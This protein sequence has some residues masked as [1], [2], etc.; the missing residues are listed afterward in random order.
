MTAPPSLEASVV[1][2]VKDDPRIFRLLTSLACQSVSTDRFEVLVVENGSR[3][4]GERVSA[5]GGHVRYLH[6]PSSNPAAARGVGLQAARGRFLLLT[7]ADCVVAEDWIECLTQRLARGDLAAVGGVIEKYSPQS[8]T[9]RHGI[10]VVDGQHSLNYLPALDLPYVV[11]ANAGYVA[12][13]VREV[14]GF[15]E[16]LPSGSDVDICYR[17]GLAGYA[18]GLAPNA[19]VRHED[20]RTIAAHFDRFRYYAEYQVLLF[21]KYRSHSG[22]RFVLNPYPLRRLLRAGIALPAA[23]ARLVRGDPGPAATVL[24]QVVEVIA[25]WSGDVIG[26]IKHRQFYL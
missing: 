12:A 21:A 13:K 11:S 9:Q 4:L 3:E 24:L 22:K 5:L 17:L 20:R 25:I 16:A 7:D 6:S 8:V 19:V 10:T 26:S 23:L 1:V 18:V 14:G 15:D 2:P